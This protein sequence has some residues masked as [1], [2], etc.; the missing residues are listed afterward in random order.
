[1][2]RVVPV[3][4]DPWMCNDV[5]V[6]TL[7]NTRTNEITDIPLD[8]YLKQ[9]VAFKH[10]WKQFRVG[11]E[12]PTKPTSF[13]PYLVGLY[14]AE[15]TWSSPQITNPEPEV[16]KFLFEWSFKNH[17]IMRTVKKK[18]HKEFLFTSLD[19]RHGKNKMST[20]RKS[21]TSQDDRWIP[22]EYLVNSE[23]IRLQ[24]LAGLVDGDGYLGQGAFEIITKYASLNRDILF[25]ARSLGFCAYSKKKIGRIK[26]LGFEAEYYRIVIGGDI[27]QIPNKVL[28]KKASPRRQIK[29]VLKTGFKVESVGEG[30][31][32]GFTLDSDGRFLLGDFTVTHNTRSFCSITIDHALLSPEK[33]PT[34]IIVHRKELVQQISLTLAEEEI[35]HNIIA[36]RPVILGIVAAHRRVFKKQFYDYNSKVT[37]VSVDTLNARV[38]KHKKWAEGIRLWITD[39]AAHLLKNNKWGKAVE[40]F[41][42]AIGL[43]VTATPRRLDKRGLGSHADGVFDHMVIGPDSKWGIANGYLSKYKIAIPSSDYQ[44]FLKKASEGSDYSK[45]TMIEAS[46]KSRIVGDVVTNYLKFA[47]GKQAILFA[48]DI[49]TGEKMEKKFIDAGVKAK[50]LTGLTNDKE[51]LESLIDFQ[52]KRIQVLLNVDLFDEGLDVPGIECVIMARPTMS[53]SKYK[54][55]VGRGLRP[56]PNK[57]YLIIIDHVGNVTTHGL[58][59]AKRRWT[60]D[61]IVKK[62]ETTNFIR[63]CSNIDCNAPYDRTL[64]ECPWCGNPAF[65]INRGEGSGRVPPKQV[66]GDLELIDPDTL[67]EMEYNAVLEIPEI[68]GKK[69]SFVAGAPAGIKA[70]KDQAKRIETQKELVNVI[71]K[72]AGIHRAQGYAD[73]A[74]HKKFFLEF[75]KTISQALAEPRAD[76]VETMEKLKDSAG[77]EWFKGESNERVRDPAKDSD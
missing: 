37:V 44:N 42:N 16:E 35:A 26:S 59:D 6:L 18:N 48:T 61:R 2:F 76:M 41:P 43:G 66:D 49:S 13:D 27:D 30:D 20:L 7:K 11:V 19:R 51:R 23:E 57:E 73:R 69:V 72:W 71:A 29:S 4:G 8:Q 14:L 40:L 67:R 3:K 24:I 31:Y 63:I 45:E 10:E 32:F 68:V 77:H 17:Q 34:A 52:E 53:V 60:L 28:R 74:I 21:C 46:E 70:M 1:M 39:E 25:L 5:H 9:N 50:L 65:S 62:R 54:Q 33:K 75:D 55:M 38:H 22:K 56:A 12:F 64:S 36:P 58:P 15:G 47:K